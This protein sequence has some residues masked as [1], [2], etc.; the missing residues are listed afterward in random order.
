MKAIFITGAAQGIGLAIARLF[1]EKGWLVGLY[2]INE[3]LCKDHLRD[4]LLHRAVAGFCD[5]TDS[6]SVAAALAA[7]TDASG[8]KLDVLVNN[9]GVLSAGDFSEMS[10]SNINAM[11]A[12]NIGGLTTVSHQA[13]PYLRDTEDAVVLNL[14][15]ASSIHGIPWLGVYSASKFYVD[16]LTQALAIEW[17]DHDIHVT[18]LK[19]PPIN[20]AMGHQLDSRHTKKMPINMQVEQVADEAFA[21]IVERKPHRI[22]GRNT[23]AWY[24]V[25]GLLPAS[26]RSRLTRYITGA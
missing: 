14:C 22:L 25:N 24:V 21:A 26:L 10:S 6:D 19:P 23:K 13:F 5:V 17:Q 8:G 3:N 20:T 1:A 15:S 4:P 11:I 9:A 7:F 2:D 18:C 12:V 16:G